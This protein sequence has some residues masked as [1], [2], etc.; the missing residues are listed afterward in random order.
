MTVGQASIPKAFRLSIPRAE[1]PT[2]RR[3]GGSGWRFSAFNVVSSAIGWEVPCKVSVPC[4]IARSSA[5]TSMRSDTN[6]AFG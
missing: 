5:D 2:V 6:T 3:N 1:N 4:T